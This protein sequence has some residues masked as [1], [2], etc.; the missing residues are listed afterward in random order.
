MHEIRRKL[1]AKMFGM[2]WQAAGVAK[3]IAL[4]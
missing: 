4:G 2:D 1:K 3:A